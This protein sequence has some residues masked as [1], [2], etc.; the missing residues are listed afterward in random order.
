MGWDRPDPLPW[1]QDH[2][3]NVWEA[4]GRPGRSVLDF[5]AS[6]NPLGPPP[7]L[8]EHLQARWPWIV[9]YPDRRAREFAAA[10]AR[11]YG[12]PAG[13]VLAGN[14]SAE[15]IDLALRGLSPGRVILC[16]PD[17]GLYERCVPPGVPVLRIPRSTGQGF[18]PDLDAV[19]REVRT[20]DLV[21]LSNPS[22]PAGTAVAAEDLLETAHRCARA[23]AVLVVDEAFADFCPRV[24]LLAHATREPALLVLRSLTKFYG[25]PGIRIGFATGAPEL[26]RRMAAVQVPWSV[27]TLHQAAGAFCLALEDWPDRTQG[28]VDRTRRELQESLEALPGLSVVPGARANYLLVRLDPPAPGATGAYEFLAARG[29]LVRHCGSFGLGERYVR[30]AVRSPRENQRLVQALASLL[31]RGPRPGVERA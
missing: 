31:G 13:A 24:S 18:A 10:A 25:I 7:G 19:A 3:G 22:N 28:F 1:Q 15:L 27:G 5:S 16:P 8:L 17:F 20:G 29:I 30:V 12:L 2:G 23:G 9:H 6:V 4:P 26:L 11:R 14:G 21:V